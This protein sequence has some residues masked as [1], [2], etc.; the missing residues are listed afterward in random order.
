M[1]VVVY[2]FRGYRVRKPARFGCLNRPM[3][4]ASVKLEY[5]P[6]LPGQHRLYRRASQLIRHMHGKE[7]LG[8][9]R[10]R[11]VR[12]INTSSFGSTLKRR[13]NLLRHE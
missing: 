2:N 6:E 12:Y 9:P 10:L 5:A 3:L 1:I 11:Y 7:A 8:M 4:L 13:T